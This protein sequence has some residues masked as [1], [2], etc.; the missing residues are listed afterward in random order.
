MN[1]DDAKSTQIY[2]KSRVSG[3]V[4]LVTVVEFGLRCAANRGL[5]SV[6]QGAGSFLSKRAPS[7]PR[8]HSGSLSE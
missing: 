2:Q 1:A 6:S 7:G 5:T 3:V 4:R 8:G